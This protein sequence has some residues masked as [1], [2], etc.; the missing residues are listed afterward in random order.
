MNERRN[1]RPQ[2]AA[3]TEQ[4]QPNPIAAAYDKLKAALAAGKDDP[5]ARA[6]LQAEMPTDSDTGAAT[7]TGADIAEGLRSENEAAREQARSEI[8]KLLAPGPALANV[9]TEHSS[10]PPPVS[11]LVKGW[12][13]DATLSVLTGAGG[14]GKSRIASAVGSVSGNRRRTLHSDR[15]RRSHAERPNSARTACHRAGRL[16]R[17]GNQASCMAEPPCRH[18]RSRSGPNRTNPAIVRPV[19]LRQYA[20]RGWPLGCRARR[21]HKHRR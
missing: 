7:P 9:L 19:A 15:E 10:N 11:W 21:T 1:G 5:S 20:A 13:P 3:E 6:T 2:I 8:Q 18:L 17:L 16:C 4:I 14:A 12:M